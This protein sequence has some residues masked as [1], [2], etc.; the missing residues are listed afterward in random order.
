MSI[1]LSY[2]NLANPHFLKAMKKLGRSIFKD[3][4]A[5]YNVARLI[6]LLEPELR[7]FNQLRDKFAVKVMAAKPAKDAEESEADKAKFEELKEE[8][9]KLREISFTIERHKVKLEDASGAD[10]T[11]LEIIALEPI[12]EISEMT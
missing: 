6:S 10:L 11:P 7:T 9:N 5:S 1:T 4:K 8:E 12:L 2:D 3:P